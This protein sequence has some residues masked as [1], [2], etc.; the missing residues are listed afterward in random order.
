VLGEQEDMANPDATSDSSPRAG[1]AVEFFVTDS[2]QKFE[3]LGRMFLGRP[4]ENIT[5]V[6]LKE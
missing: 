6:E 1:G 4:I 2:V 5:H 3:R